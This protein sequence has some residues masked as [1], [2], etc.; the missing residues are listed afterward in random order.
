MRWVGVCNCSV[1]QMKKLM[2]VGPIT[3]HQM[4]YSLLRPTP[5]TARLAYLML[6]KMGG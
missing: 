3:S 2:P 5:D 6:A 4:H 1:D